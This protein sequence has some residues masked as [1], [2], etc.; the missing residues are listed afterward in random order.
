MRCLAIVVGRGR[1]GTG[2]IETSVGRRRGGT[3]S[4]ERSVVRAASGLGLRALTENAPEQI[5][6]VL[7]A[8]LLQDAGTVTFDR[9]RAQI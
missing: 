2:S 9:P 4:V 8:G 5:G 7:G 1:E 6:H 3:M